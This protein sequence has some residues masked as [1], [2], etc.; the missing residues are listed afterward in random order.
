MAEES[1]WKYTPWQNYYQIMHCNEQQFQKYVFKSW[2][3]NLCLSVTN[4]RAWQTTEHEKQ[5]SLT[6][7]RAWRITERDKQQSVTNNRAWRSTERDKQQSVKNNRAWRTTERDKQQ[8]VTNNRAWQTTERDK[9]KLDTFQNRCLRQMLRIRWQVNRKW[10]WI[11]HV[12]RMDNT[13]IC[14]TALTCMASKRKV[15]SRQTYNNTED[16]HWARTNKAWLE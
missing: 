1:G 15:N 9:Q 16:N 8:S 13:R 6:N 5:Q 10:D 12:L 3:I 2:K 11:Y 4:N 7:N 14:T